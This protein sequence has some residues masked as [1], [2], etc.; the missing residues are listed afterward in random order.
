MTHPLLPKLE[1][2]THKVASLHGFELCGVQLLTH[3]SPITLQVRIRHTDGTDVSLDDCANFSNV[4]GQTLEES[5]GLTE[6]Y[7]LEISSPG[8]GKQ[9]AYDRDFQT[10]RGFPVRVTYRG[11][12]DVQQCLDGLLLERSDSMLRI[13]IHGKI[14]SIPCDRVTEVRLTTPGQ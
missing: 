9:L 14:K 3:M 2:L 6:A 5:S 12:N 7:V 10:F 4:L 11:K 8:I 1:Q 13:N